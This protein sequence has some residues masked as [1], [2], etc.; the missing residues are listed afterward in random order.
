MTLGRAH[1][2]ITIECDGKNIQQV[3]QFK[4]LGSI[5]TENGEYSTEIKARLGHARAEVRNLSKNLEE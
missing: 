3:T 4:Y 2:D 1:E 5:I